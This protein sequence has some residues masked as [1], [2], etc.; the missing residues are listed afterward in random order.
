[1]KRVLNVAAGVCRRAV[2]LVLGCVL[3]F[4]ASAS[5]SAQGVTTGILNGTV[6][7]GSGKPAEGASVIAIHLPSGTSYAATTR[8]DGRFSIPG[9]RV[10]GPY[11]VTVTYM[12]AGLA[13][14]PSTQEDV[15]VNLGVA[16]DLHFIVRS[17]A[18]E[19]TITVTGQSDTIFASS[20][21]GAATSVSRFEL[22]TV[23]TISGRLNDLTRLTP[24]AAG[25]SFAGQDNRLNNITVDGSSFNNSFGLAGAP[26][27]RTGVAPISLE[28]IEQV[29]VSVAPFDV[30]QG[31]FVEHVGLIVGHQIHGES[32]AR[33][34]PVHRCAQVTHERREVCPNGVGN[35]LIDLEVDLQP[36]RGRTVPQQIDQVLLEVS[37]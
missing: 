22:A 34:E 15:M 33:A 19:E 16:T 32:Q 1:M 30:R 5:A 14:E 35:D 27:E 10:G 31:S 12:G 25:M 28:S 23:P 26:G 4:G 9:M 11:S 29:Q 24:Q 18:V 13:F 36:A 2:A 8:A 3:L 6:I 17:I 21:T 7:D 20:R 37:R